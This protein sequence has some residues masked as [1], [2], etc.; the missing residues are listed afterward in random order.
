[1]PANPAPSCRTC[2]A[3]ILR[4]CYVGMKTVKFVTEMG[5]EKNMPAVQWMGPCPFYLR[6]PGAD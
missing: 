3:Y 4:P 6:E 1:M 2:T 5:C